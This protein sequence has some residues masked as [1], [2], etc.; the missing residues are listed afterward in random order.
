[1]KATWDGNSES[2]SENKDQQEISNMCFMAMV[3]VKSL[4]LNDESSDDEFDDEFDDLSYEELLNDFNDLH[5]NYENLIFKNGALKKKISSF[6]KE[7]EDFSKENKV[8]LTCDT[9]NSL[10][11]EILP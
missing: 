10:K 5:R 4:E 3:E 11:N 8:I 9:Y 1:M 7:L 6:S 2:E